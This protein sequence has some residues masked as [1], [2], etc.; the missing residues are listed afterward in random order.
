MNLKL[1][2]LA[3]NGLL[4]A[5][6]IALTFLTYPISFGAI[7]FRVSEILIFLCFFRKDFIFGLTLGCMISNFA[8]FNPVDILFGTIATILACLVVVFSRHM[9]LGIIA[10]T[11]FNAFIIGAEL[12][13]V[14]KE[15]FWLSTLTVGIGELTVLIL[16]YILFRYLGKKKWFL[17]FIRAN[18][19]LDF[20]I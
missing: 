4:I 7:Q 2:H 16:G 20:K 9:F 15:P 19:N 14:L 10:P 13:F 8:S 3:D 6:Y 17:Q 18:Q 5:A 1:R 11:L 12:F